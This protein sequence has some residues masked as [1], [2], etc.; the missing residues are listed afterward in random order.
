[1]LFVPLGK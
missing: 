1:M